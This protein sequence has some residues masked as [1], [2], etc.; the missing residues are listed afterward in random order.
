[1]KV[2]RGQSE[3]VQSPDPYE[4]QVVP[5]LV[6]IICQGPGIVLKLKKAGCALLC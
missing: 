2:G 5:G 1:M 3:R 4:T 6:P